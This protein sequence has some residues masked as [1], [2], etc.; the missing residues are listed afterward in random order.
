MQAA[1]F[2]SLEDMGDLTHIKKRAPKGPDTHVVISWGEDKEWTTDIVKDN[3]N[4][5]WTGLGGGE[6]ILHRKVRHSELGRDN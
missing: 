4:P 6:L 3:R 1:M 5:I 2:S